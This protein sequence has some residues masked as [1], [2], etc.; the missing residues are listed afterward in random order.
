MA[1]ALRGLSK[2]S[3][4][5]RMPE[6][7][8]G[9]SSNFILNVLEDTIIQSPL[10]PHESAE[11]TFEALSPE[12]R[13]K[14]W[15]DG[16]AQLS[17]AKHTANSLPP[18]ALTEM[19]VNRYFQTAH[20]IFPILGRKHFDATSENFWEGRPTEGQGYEIWTAVL[21]MV[22]ALGHQYC[23]IDPDDEVR[24]RA[25]SSPRDG[26]RCFQLM[27]LSCSDVVF[28]GG[29]ISV[30]NCL[31]LAVRQFLELEMLAT[32]MLTTDCAVFVALQSE[33]TP[34]SLQ[35]TRHGGQNLL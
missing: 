31:L 15:L 32:L 20:H 6:F 25:L 13:A 29:D 5:A 10:L 14:L 27:K 28:E 4:G 18:R 24:Q 8:G 22:A 2:I 11:S 16:S 1:Q 12:N 9:S 34:R 19:Y 3:L 30:V 7:Y 17:F 21:C 26:E 23:L 33:P 35:L